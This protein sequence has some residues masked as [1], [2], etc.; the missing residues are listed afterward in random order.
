[1]SFPSFLWVEIRGFYLPVLVWIWSICYSP[2]HYRYDRGDAHRREVTGLR[3]C[4]LGWGGA[5]RSVAGGRRRR[6][7]CRREKVTKKQRPSGRFS[8]YSKGYRRRT[9]YGGAPT[10]FFIYF[11]SKSKSWRN[12][13]F[14]FEFD[15][16]KLSKFSE[17]V[18][19][20]CKFL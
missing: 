12:S 1:M 3:R 10:V 11:S 9:K 19:I 17:G 15:E 13:C 16:S 8:I 14:R 18:E 5:C 2:L 20:R 4:S 6:R 7:E